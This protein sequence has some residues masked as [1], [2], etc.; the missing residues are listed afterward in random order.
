MTDRA[1]HNEREGFLGSSADAPARDAVPG[2]GELLEFLG[3]TPAAGAFVLSVVRPEVSEGLAHALA[4]RA[5]AFV[6]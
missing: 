2:R 1:R 6:H 4:A 5:A 3:L